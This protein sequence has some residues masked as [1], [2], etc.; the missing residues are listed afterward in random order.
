AAGNGPR[1]VIYVS[2]HSS[3]LDIPALGHILRAPFVAKG[4]VATWPVVSLIAR[5]GRTVFVTR[6]RAGIAGERA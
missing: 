6:N 3:W 4:E 2:N 5:L 1:P